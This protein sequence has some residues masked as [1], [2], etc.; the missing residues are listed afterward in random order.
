MSIEFYDPSEVDFEQ[1]L[2][3]EIEVREWENVVRSLVV[4][5]RERFHLFTDN[6]D[7]TVKVVRK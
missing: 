7:G 4:E 2:L 3:T 5:G 6:F 1:T